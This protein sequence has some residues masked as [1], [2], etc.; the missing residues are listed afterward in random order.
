MGIT[1]R[2]SLFTIDVVKD[3]SQSDTSNVKDMSTMFQSTINFNGYISQ[4][5]T[6]NVTDM[7]Q[8]NDNIVNSFC[9]MSNDRILK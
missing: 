7:F 5:D 3:I 8:Y 1:L 4:R 2:D 6:S 9:S